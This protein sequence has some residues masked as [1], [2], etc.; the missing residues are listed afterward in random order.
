MYTRHVL[1]HDATTILQKQTRAGIVTSPTSQDG[2]AR[3]Q[4]GRPVETRPPGKQVIDRDLMAW[5][6]A[7]SLPVRPTT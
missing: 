5:E 2:R 7:F 4:G 6:I 1:R 3:I